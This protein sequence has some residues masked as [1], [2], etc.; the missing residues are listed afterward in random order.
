MFETIYGVFD[1]YE[2]P[3]GDEV[4]ETTDFKEVKKF[5]KEYTEECDGECKL[6]ILKREIRI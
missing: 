2:N 3:F 4:F 1:F 5:C 6:K